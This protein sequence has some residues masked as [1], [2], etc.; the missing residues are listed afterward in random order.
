MSLRLSLFGIVLSVLPAMSFA[1]TV[2]ECSFPKMANGWVEGP[3]A[4][5]LK[6]GASV[7]TV[8]S[9][10]V[11][12]F[13]GKPV[14]AKVVLNDPKL[15]VLGWSVKMKNSENQYTTMRYRLRTPPG[16]GKAEYSGEP[17]GYHNDFRNT[18][19]CKRVK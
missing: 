12:H 8:D 16:G 13:V 6:E 9:A 5:H 11:N 18:G 19:R 7:A 15:L 17:S 4:F 1:D 2:M 3:V 10:Y 14:E